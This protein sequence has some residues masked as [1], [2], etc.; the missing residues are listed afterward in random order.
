MGREARCMSGKILPENILEM[1]STVF[2]NVDFLVCVCVEGGGG[3]GVLF[4]LVKYELL[5]TVYTLHICDPKC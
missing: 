2:F 5:Y 3:G 4:L 1:K